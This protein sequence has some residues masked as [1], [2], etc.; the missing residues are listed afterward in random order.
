MPK[1][2]QMDKEPA[3]EMHYA[4]IAA[5]E[6]ARLQQ[7]GVTVP[8]P[9]IKVDGVPMIDRLIDIF[10][11]NGASSISVI[12]NKQMD[13]VRKHL[14]SLSVGCPLH[15]VVQSTPSSMHSLAA[16]SKVIPAGKFCLTTV[17]TIFDEREFSSFIRTFAL[18]KEKDCDGL[19]AVTPFVDDEKPLWVAV[20]PNDNPS[21][22][23]CEYDARNIGRVEGFYDQ[24]DE[25]PAEAAVCVSGGIYCLNTHSALPVLRECL[26]QGQSRMRNYQ[27]ALIA[28]GLKIRAYT[29]PKM[30]DIDHASDIAKAAT[31][32]RKQYQRKALAISRDVVYSPNNEVKDA[33]IFSAVL[34]RLRQQGWQIEECLEDELVRMPRESL[35]EHFK[36]VVHMARRSESLMRLE[37]LP[38]CVINAPRGVRIVAK[39]R[40]ETLKLLAQAGVLV[41][42]SCEFPAWVK[43][44]REEGVHPQDLC[45][46]QTQEEADRCI[47]RLK[48]ECVRDIVVSRHIEGELVKCYA[49]QEDGH[50]LFFH[51]FRPQ[52]CGYSKFGMAEQHNDRLP[53]VQV[54]EMHLRSLAQK[55]GMAVG[56]QVF[57]FDAILQPDGQLVVIDVN[58]WPSFSICRDEAAEAI[59][60]M[61]NN[62]R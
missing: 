10:V 24:R 43:A 62:K 36:V 49:V 41:P 22:R 46:V 60:R 23:G 4:V 8:K 29:F 32:L 52:E 50:L 21:L 27:R 14:E 15:L 20:R 56:L 25:M 58:D 57:G 51:C 30:M 34:E 47:G 5:G 16:L 48:S 3:H 11:R 6:G 53:D 28:A 9:L 26:A 33:A 44:M 18:M 2:F 39:S 59:A 40:T 19:F 37:S 42:A 45:F 12:C 13:E 61:I 7:E 17:D 31:W 35:T 1:L 55:I 54:D 38:I